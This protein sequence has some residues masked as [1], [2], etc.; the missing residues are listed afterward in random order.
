MYVRSPA[1]MI[2]TVFSLHQHTTNPYS[3]HEPIDGGRKTELRTVNRF[4]LSRLLFAACL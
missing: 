2:V 1:G 4:F 3:L